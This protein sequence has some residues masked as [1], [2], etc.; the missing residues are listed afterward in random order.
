MGQRG[1]GPITLWLELE[2]RCNIR[3]RFCYNY[4]KDKT[5]AAPQPLPTEAL[6]ECLER[7]LDEVE[8]ERVALSG[9]EPL[10]HPD[11]DR[12]LAFFQARG[13]PTVLTT[14]GTFLSSERLA[15]LRSLG[16]GAVQIPLHAAVPEIHDELSGARCWHRSI[17]A[18]ALARSMRID[19]TA[20]FVATQANLM[21]IEGVLELLYLL[22]IHRVI[23]NRFVSSGAGRLNERDLKVSDHR[24]LDALYLANSTAGRVDS[25]IELGVRVPLTDRQRAELPSVLVKSCELDGFH[26]QFTVDAA[27]DLKHCNQSPYPLGNLRQ[28]TFSS[29]VPRLPELK[30]HL[31]QVSVESCYCASL[32]FG[33]QAVDV[34][35]KASRP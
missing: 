2:V 12:F 21:L 11:L 17:R 13:I 10:M 29:L 19:V 32:E 9:G 33:A 1:Y 26:R 8:C 27:G 15:A 24:V 7:L 14:N 30:R 6:L 23:F 5:H 22:G 31:A 34:S 20:V 4:W 18:L 35:A 28:K 16:L 3:C 25:I